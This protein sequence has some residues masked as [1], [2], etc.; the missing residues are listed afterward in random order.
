M[1]CVCVWLGR[2]GVNSWNIVWLCFVGFILFTGQQVQVL[3]LC[4][5]L[6]RED[7]NILPPS[8]YFSSVSL[9][10]SSFPDP[11]IS[12]FP[13]TALPPSLSLLSPFLPLFSLFLS[14]PYCPTFLS[15]ISLLPISL[16]ISLFP[17]PSL[18]S[19][20]SLPSSPFSPSLSLFIPPSTCP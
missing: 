10:I 20:R 13:F 17:P 18:S 5:C 3:L 16:L 7:N 6:I 1:V 9:F 12:F 2:G 11:F 4:T 8:L 19:Y 15:L 14:P